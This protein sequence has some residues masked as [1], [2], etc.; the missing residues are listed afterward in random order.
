MSETL[1]L[2]GAL[3]LREAFGIIGTPLARLPAARITGCRRQA[4]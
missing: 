2:D 3:T 1:V 4:P